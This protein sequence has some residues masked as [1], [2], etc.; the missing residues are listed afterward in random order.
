LGGYRLQRAADAAF[1]DPTT[2]YD[3][4]QTRF[5]EPTL[6]TLLKHSYYRVR[7]VGSLWSLDS[8][9]SNVVELRPL[10]FGGLGALL[11]PGESA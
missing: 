11:S 1:S 9:W 4:P 10:S 5:V 2:L 8:P 3:G 7:A 6:G